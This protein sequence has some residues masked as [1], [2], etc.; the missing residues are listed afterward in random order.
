VNS[1]IAA[2][3]IEATQERQAFRARIKKEKTLLVEEA[4]ESEADPERK[5]IEKKTSSTKLQCY[6]LRGRVTDDAVLRF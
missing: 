4:L 6:C 1:K 3:K 2:L 5:I